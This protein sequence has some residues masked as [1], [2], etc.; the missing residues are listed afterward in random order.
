VIALSPKER[1]SLQAWAPTLELA[2]EIEAGLQK[3]DPNVASQ[4]IKNGWTSTYWYL[5]GRSA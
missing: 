3:L 5:Q 4:L 2:Q 1:E